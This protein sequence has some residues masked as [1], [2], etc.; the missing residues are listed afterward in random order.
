[1]TKILSLIKYY[2]D[3]NSLNLLGDMSDKPLITW[4]PKTYPN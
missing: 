4:T 2:Y 3:V 1:M